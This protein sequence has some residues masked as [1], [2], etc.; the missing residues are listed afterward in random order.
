L[1]GKISTIFPG[2]I[3]YSIPSILERYLLSELARSDP[4]ESKAPVMCGKHG[5]LIPLLEP[6]KDPLLDAL[7]NECMEKHT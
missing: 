1:W 4:M 5:S 7:K 2:T 6:G 3:F